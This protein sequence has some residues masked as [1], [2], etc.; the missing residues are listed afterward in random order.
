VTFTDDDV[1]E[2]YDLTN[3]WAAEQWSS[4]RFHNELIMAA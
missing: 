2:L 1:A 4:D 3:P